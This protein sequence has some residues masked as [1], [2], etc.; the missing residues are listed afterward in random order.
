MF[1]IPASLRRRLFRKPGAYARDERGVS[2]LE[3]ALVAGP[4]LLLLTG[5]LEIGLVLI[6][7]TGMKQGLGDAARQIRIGAAQC[8]SRDEIEEIICDGA[9]LLPNCSER[10]VVKQTAS[11]LGFGAGMASQL[12]GDVFN[13]VKGGE[14]V[15]VESTYRWEILSPLLSPLLGDASGDLVIQDSFVFQN[16]TFG[17]QSCS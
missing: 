17:A 8:L 14:V 6:A 10:L 1:S 3:F 7:G 13:E 15:I 11:P 4:F 5:I 12:S 2:T 9:S 16:E